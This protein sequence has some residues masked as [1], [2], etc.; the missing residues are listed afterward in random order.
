MSKRCPDACGIHG[1]FPI[2]VFFFDFI[3]F[4]SSTYLPAPTHPFTSH[5]YSMYFIPIL[6]CCH[7]PCVPLAYPFSTTVV[8][9]CY[10]IFLEFCTFAVYMNIYPWV[11]FFTLFSWYGNAYMSLLLIE[12]ES[13]PLNELVFGHPPSPDRRIEMT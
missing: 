13:F 5:Y 9:V 2:L 4:S 3:S 11:Y 12:H 6:D 1:S 8:S 10:F 7:C